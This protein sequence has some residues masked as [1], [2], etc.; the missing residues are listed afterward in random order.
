MYYRN[1]GIGIWIFLAG[2]VWLCVNGFL[3][4]KASGIADDKGYDK[5]TWFHMCF[6]LGPLS[7][8]VIA[9]MPDL[10]LREVTEKLVTMQSRMLDVFDQ[11][12]SSSKHES[13]GKSS[14]FTD[15]PII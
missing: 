15:L 12:F 14:D 5:R 9:A 11:P 7:Y 13:K 2:A 6:W 4:S 8:V 3:A 10:K 1:G